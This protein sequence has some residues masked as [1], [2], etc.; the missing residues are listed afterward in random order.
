MMKFNSEVS[1]FGFCMND[2]SIDES[3]LLDSLTTSVSGLT[4]LC[5]VVLIL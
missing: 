3:E 2:S 5:L 1:L 4:C